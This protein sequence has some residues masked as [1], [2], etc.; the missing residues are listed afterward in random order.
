MIR[1]RIYY[2]QKNLKNKRKKEEKRIM[3]NDLGLLILLGFKYRV[4]F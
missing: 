4:F 2:N 1:F 3:K